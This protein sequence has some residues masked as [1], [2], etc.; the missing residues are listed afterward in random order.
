[1][2]SNISLDNIPIGT[3]INNFNTQIEELICAIEI[4][5]P[6]INLQ[7]S[8]F[9]LNTIKKFN[10]GKVIDLFSIHVSPYFTEIFAKNEKRLLELSTDDIAEALDK[11]EAKKESFE[12]NLFKILEFKRIWKELNEHNKNVL[13]EHLQILAY[14]S[15]EYIK[16]KLFNGK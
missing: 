6:N 11:S 4:V 13:W 3:I 12:K 15:Q 2:E 1:M 16:K 8:R 5:C 10:A 9:L 14:Y 7:K